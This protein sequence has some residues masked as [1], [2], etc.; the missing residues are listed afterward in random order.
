MK[1]TLLFLLTL[2]VLLAFTFQAQAQSDQRGR[3]ASGR[4]YRIDKEGMKLVDQVAEL[5]VTIDDLNRRIIAL[6]NEI[7]DKDRKLKRISEGKGSSS[8]IGERDILSGGPKPTLPEVA[9]Q[10]PS[11]SPLLTPLQA[12]I[13]QLDKEL[14]SYKVANEALN[15][16]VALLSSQHKSLAE[17]NNLNSGR[18]G[19]EQNAAREQLARQSSDYETQLKLQNSEKE[20]LQLVVENKASE[21][22]QLQG[23]L[24]A[25]NARE[26]ELNQKIDSLNNKIVSLESSLS[27]YEKELGTQKKVTVLN[28]AARVAAGK[29][30]VVDSHPVA[31]VY[32][33]EELNERL[34]IIQKLINERKMLYDRLKDSRSNVIV[35]MQPLRT[36]NDES[37]DEVRKQILTVSSDD[38]G[39]GILEKLSE[40]EKILNEDLKLFKRMNKI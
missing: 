36:S 18:I 30:S 5:E 33:R 9:G 25:S 21:L 17:E 15:N 38:E 8:E 37:L 2:F 13:S 29:S 10:D 27:I 28:K 35:S 23:K 22:S 31:A 12:K 14:T 11:C 19:L 20:K 39:E 3:D 6:E 26:L 24:Q 16:Q 1:S 7:D 4:A 40:I 34:S 32:V